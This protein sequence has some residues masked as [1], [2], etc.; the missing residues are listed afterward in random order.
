MESLSPANN[1]QSAEIFEYNIHITTL[2]TVYENETIERRGVQNKLTP[3]GF[4]SGNFRR[5]VLM[6]YSA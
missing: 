6:M 5:K 3:T 4:L 1:Y 2:T